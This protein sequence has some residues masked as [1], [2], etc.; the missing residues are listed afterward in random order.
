MNFENELLNIELE[1]EMDEKV[2]NTRLNILAHEL[3]LTV[4]EI[5]ERVLLGELTLHDSFEEW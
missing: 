1:N 4:S 5:E 2:Y 3:G